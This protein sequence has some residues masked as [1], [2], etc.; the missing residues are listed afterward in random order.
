MFSILKRGCINS[1]S[2]ENMTGSVV[3]FIISRIHPES[4]TYEDFLI[5]AMISRSDLEIP[6]V[7]NNINIVS[8]AFNKRNVTVCYCYQSEICLEQQLENRVTFIRNRV[9]SRNI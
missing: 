5:L 2:K 6:T 8:L 9:K 7:R 4:M 1:T 3:H